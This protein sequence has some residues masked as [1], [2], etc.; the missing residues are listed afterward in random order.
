MKML[1]GLLICS[2]IML[3]SGAV[4]K[5]KNIQNKPV[6]L[7]P[8]SSNSSNTKLNT[9]QT[10]NSSTTSMPALSIN[11]TTPMP[12]SPTT[13][14]P[15]HTT[16]STTLM[17]NSSTL[18]ANVST[19]SMPGLSTNTTTVMPSSPTT[20]MPTLTTNATSLMANS[21]TNPTPVPST[22]SSTNSSA[23]SDSTVTQ[24][25]QFV[26]TSK[27]IL[28]MTQVHTKS[29]SQTTF[30]YGKTKVTTLSV[31]G[32]R[33]IHETIKK[34]G[35]TIAEI[36]DEKVPTDEWK[37]DGSNGSS[38][39]VQLNAVIE[40]SYSY[41]NKSSEL[42]AS[43]MYLPRHNM[44]QVSGNCD[45]EIKS[46]KISWADS[47]TNWIEL[48]FAKIDNKNVTVYRLSNLIVSASSLALED[49][50][51]NISTPEEYLIRECKKVNETC[52]YH[53]DEQ[54]IRTSN[55]TERM[56]HL[57]VNNLEFYITE[58]PD[59][60]EEIPYGFVY[61]GYTASIGIGFLVL[62]LFIVICIAI[63]KCGKYRG[64]KMVNRI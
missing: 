63:Y 22:N 19:T 40:A 28:N 12:S 34:T 53:F 49:F 48:S 61:P 15:T 39:T 17:A 64:Y 1:I 54:V 32:D 18:M 24:D 4:D 26:F 60:L 56:T 21:S 52:R 5:D 25:S 36:E 16:N 43:S 10:K 46:I 3:I 50:K 51:M 62:V 31:D 11:S 38:I 29:K 55:N 33:N 6:P 20:S 59:T 35:E 23:P 42:I 47:S 13:S 7:S 30:T 41:A 58:N 14:M 37:I 27:V 8:T 44:T 9:T 2:S 45:G 57:I